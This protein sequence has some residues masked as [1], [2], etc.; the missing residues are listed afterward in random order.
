MATGCIVAV[1]AA[2]RLTGASDIAATAT[3]LLDLISGLLPDIQFSD[4]RPNTSIIE[5][6][7][8]CGERFL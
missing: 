2:V 5:N 1:P 3:T 7:L 6:S 8:C 4:V